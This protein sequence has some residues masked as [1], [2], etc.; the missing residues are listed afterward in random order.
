MCLCGLC[1]LQRIMLQQVRRPQLAELIDCTNLKIFVIM[2]HSHIQKYRGR[3][4]KKKK[5]SD[6]LLKVTYPTHFQILFSSGAALNNELRT[7]P[8]SRKQHWPRRGTD[9]QN[10]VF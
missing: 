5:Y 10:W 3:N 9:F 8:I 4:N 6:F 2:N 7:L 1:C